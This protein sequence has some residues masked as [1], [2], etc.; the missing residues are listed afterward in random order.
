MILL[1]QN[2]LQNEDTIKHYRSVSVSVN[3]IDDTDTILIT[4]QEIGNIFIKY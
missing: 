1:Y 2:F 3:N 4:F